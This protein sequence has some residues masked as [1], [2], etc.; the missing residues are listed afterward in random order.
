MPWCFGLLR[1]ILTINS[2]I[3][4]PKI[5]KIFISVLLTHNALL[6]LYHSRIMT[7]T[8]NLLRTTHRPPPRAR[9][10]SPVASG[11]G[12]SMRRSDKTA[13]RTTR[14]RKTLPR[15]S[16]KA[17][18]LFG[19]LKPFFSFK[20]RE[21]WC[22]FAPSAAFSAAAFFAAAARSAAA[23]CAALNF[24]FSSGV[25]IGSMAFFGHALA[26]ILQFTHFS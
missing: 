25:G 26:H 1:T 19:S 12:K 4:R 14:K 10:D 2:V 5:K 24:S 9:R 3:N 23:F 18:S 22:Q 13:Y 15:Q 6:G 21:Q 8:Y 11:R 16:V 7:A 17:F 20:K